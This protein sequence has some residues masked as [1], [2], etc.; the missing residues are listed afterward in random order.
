MKKLAITIDGMTC[1]HCVRGVTRALGALD[2][3]QVGRV[4][5]G[6]AEVAFDP[7]SVSP[8]QIAAAVEEEGYAVTQTQA[9]E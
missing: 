9:D 6:S 2:G 3:V 1:D 5:V 8:A 4:E 7:A